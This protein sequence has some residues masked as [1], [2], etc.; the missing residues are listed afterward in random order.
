MDSGDVQ[1][2]LKEFKQIEHLAKTVNSSGQ[3]PSNSKSNQMST[4]NVPRS[5]TLP[6][7]DVAG[8]RSRFEGR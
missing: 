2:R 1:P 7:K 4:E 8:P 5:C 6:P 3:G